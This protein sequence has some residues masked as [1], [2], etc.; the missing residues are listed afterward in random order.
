MSMLHLDGRVDARVMV[1]GD[2]GEPIFLCTPPKGRWLVKGKPENRLCLCCV[3]WRGW[4]AYMA[5][6]PITGLVSSAEQ[7]SVLDNPLCLRQCVAF[8]R[9]LKKH[10]LGHTYLTG[11]VCC[12]W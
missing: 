2:L 9:K 1:V 5:E 7:L 6:L 11:P 12:I 10:A 8:W 4:V 3:L